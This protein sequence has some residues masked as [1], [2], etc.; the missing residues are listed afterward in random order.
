MNTALILT[1]SELCKL[2]EPAGK[3]LSAPLAALLE[4]IGCQ[5]CDH[6]KDQIQLSLQKKG[7]VTLDGQ[8]LKLAPILNLIVSQAL[9]AIA[10]KEIFPGT[11]ILECPKMLLL[12]SKYE[13]AVETWRISPFQD[14]ASLMLSFE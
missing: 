11:Y 12:F 8:A 9:E 6:D 10:F 14:M 5:N 3:V 13:R 7:L 4:A 2:L 1:K